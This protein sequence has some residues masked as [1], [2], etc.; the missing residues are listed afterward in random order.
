MA[1]SND[2]IKTFVAASALVRG[3]A[4]TINSSGQAAYTGV[5]E[6]ADGIV[7]RDTA[8][9]GDA[10]VKLKYSN[11]SMELMMVTAVAV[12]GLIWSAASGKGS[13]TAAVGN[14]QWKAIS[15]AATADGD[16]IEVVPLPGAR[17]GEG[18]VT[19]AHTA[20]DTL[21]LSESGSIHTTFGAGG[22]VTFTLPA[23][24]VGLEFFFQVG[25]AQNLV[26][27]PV[28]AETV[29]LPSTGVAQTNITANAIGESVH[30][31]CCQAGTWAVMGFTG[32]WT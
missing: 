29:S 12:G 16:L 13:G 22:A 14:P 23:A 25:A 20:D 28:G 11:G 19:E 6:D 27:E 24:T 15:Q 17:Q 31:M 3:R 32:T 18:R 5:G 4:V 21:L 26:V 10:P 2:G 9:G 1:V 8:S 7:Q 30:I